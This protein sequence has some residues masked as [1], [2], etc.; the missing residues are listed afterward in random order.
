MQ[1]IGKAVRRILLALA[2]VL[3]AVPAWAQT[4][5]QPALEEAPAP[6]QLAAD[7]FETIAYVPVT[8]QPLVGGLRSGEMIITHYKPPGDGPFPALI[9]LHGRG[10]DRAKPGRW[11][12]LDIARHW[13]RRGFAVFVP[14]RLGY[15]DTGLQPDP[16]ST[17]PCNGK[18]FEVAA[19]AA[20]RQVLATIDFAVAQPWIDKSKVIVK[21]QSVGGFAAIATVGKNH[22]SVIAS[23]NFAGGAGGDPKTRPG[24]PCQGER[25]GAVYAAAG[26]ANAGA[27]PTLW[28]YAENDNYW[29]Q[30]LPRRWHAAFTEAGGQAEFVMFPPLGNEG[31]ALLRNGRHLWRPAVDRFLGQLGI[32]VPKSANA[33]PPSRFAGLDDVGKLPHVSA[34]VKENGYRRFLAADV[35]RAFAIGPRGEWSYVSGDSAIKRALERCAGYA[36]LECKLYAVDDAVVWAP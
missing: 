7:L 16:E 2:G 17:G 23:I 33:P 19:E 35:P 10:S 9:A 26:S 28:L 32:A 11:R 27:T 31:H 4:N 20:S 8:V 18:R 22:P 6:P 21:G 30:T 25:L 24:N 12:Y 1:A 29:G 34:E 3:V 13:T 36:K 15:G 14:T 5:S